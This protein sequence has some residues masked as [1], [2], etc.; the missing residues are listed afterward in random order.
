MTNP[1]AVY[2]N[3]IEF[4]ERAASIYFVMA[5]RFSPQNPELSA[6]WLDMGIQEKQHSGLLQFC[7]MEGLFADREPREEQVRKLETEFASLEKRAADPDLTIPSAFEIAIAMEL[8]EVNDIYTLLTTPLH[9]SMYL[10]RRKTT[11]SMPDHLER[12][13]QEAR[14]YGV[15]EGALKNL[16][17]ATTQ[18]R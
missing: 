9:R 18:D 10:L 15:K 2:Q 5:S 14:N 12:L 1:Q 4:E 7:V 11:A 17:R 3:F 6:L 13:L 8:S 16:E